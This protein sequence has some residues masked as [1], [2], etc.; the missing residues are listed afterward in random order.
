MQT[1][2]NTLYIRGVKRLH[3]LTRKDAPADPHDISAYTN[4]F[5][6][7]CL[8]QTSCNQGTFKPTKVRR[9]AT[10][11]THNDPVK[12][13]QNVTITNTVVQSYMPMTSRSYGGEAKA[14]AD[15]KAVKYTFITNSLET[16]GPLNSVGLRF[17]GDLKVGTPHL[18]SFQ[19]PTRERLPVST[20]QRRLRS[21]SIR[22][23]FPIHTH[24]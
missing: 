17:L 6:V 11:W 3:S 15:R 22:R 14:E 23:T 9:K 7:H 18:L 20:L 19:W 2:A 21:R 8:Q 12:E 5:G 10:R 13:M 24:L 4:S 1:I 16:Q